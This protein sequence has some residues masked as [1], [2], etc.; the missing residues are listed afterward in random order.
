MQPGMQP[1]PFAQYRAPMQMAPP[2]VQDWAPFNPGPIQRIPSWAPADPFAYQRIPFDIAPVAQVPN[3]D[4]IWYLSGD[5]RKPAQ[6]IQRRL[7]GRAL[8]INEQG[9][10]AL[11]TIEG[12]MV[13]I[14]EWT[15]GF[16]RGLVGTVRGDRITWPDGNF[17]SRTPQ[18]PLWYR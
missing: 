10:E 2:M 11:G 1:S 5:P 4:G 17:W 3:L 13:F 8:F 14:P 6:I 18:S 9:S 12:D 7:D 16:N 15:D